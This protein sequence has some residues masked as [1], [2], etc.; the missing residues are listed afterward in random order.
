M[1]G[2]GFSDEH[3]GIFLLTWVW[4]YLLPA[5][6]YYLRDLRRGVRPLTTYLTA[7]PNF[8]CAVIGWCIRPKGRSSWIAAR[9]ALEREEKALEV[10]LQAQ[11]PQVA[12]RRNI[13][14]EHLA[15]SVELQHSLLA[16]VR[17]S[18]GRPESLRSA[19]AALECAEESRPL[20]CKDAGL[21]LHLLQR[22]ALLAA[23]FALSGWIHTAFV[24]DP[25]AV[26]GVPQHS[27]AQAVERAFRKK[28]LTM[29]PD[30]GGDPKAFRNLQSAKDIVL[31][32]SGRDDELLGTN[33]AIPK[34]MNNIYVVSALLFAVILAPITLLFGAVVLSF[35]YPMLFVGCHSV[36]LWHLLCVQCG[37]AA[38][39][40][41]IAWALVHGLVALPA[42][43]VTRRA[44]RLLS[45][46]SLWFLWGPSGFFLTDWVAE[47]PTET[48]RDGVSTARCSR[49]TAAHGDE[50]SKQ[51]T[52][53]P[54]K[55]KA[56]SDAAIGVD[57][58]NDVNTKIT[59]S[60]KTA[61][62]SGPVAGKRIQKG[63][64]KGSTAATSKLTKTVETV[65]K[66]TTTSTSR[67]SSENAG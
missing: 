4:L 18:T 46:R 11:V 15:A 23:R 39:H 41:L 67:C 59:N 6:C 25:W 29:H 28:S 63:A 43:L 21:A 30:K 44:D 65:K 57:G 27:A 55:S 48:A 3:F 35:L 53:K 1:P 20:A 10:H 61:V 51:I 33:Y 66:S 19:A 42:L 12:A 17:T 40:V 24:Y 58:V 32:R 7:L 14:P 52:A 56:R 16:Q 9:E 64:L 31:S 54:K 45:L 8:W 13:P 38:R 47:M 60:T 22:T 49:P 5:G 34:F 50:H 36:L 37:L 2:P 62:A 26:L